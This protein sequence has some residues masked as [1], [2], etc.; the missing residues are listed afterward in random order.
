MHVC[1]RQ[2]L[3]TALLALIRRRLF[4][5]L[6]L[7]KKRRTFISCRTDSTSQPCTDIYQHKLLYIFSIYIYK[8]YTYYCDQMQNITST[9]EDDHIDGWWWW[10]QKIKENAAKKTRENTKTKQT[11]LVLSSKVAFG[12]DFNKFIRWDNINTHSPLRRIDEN[13]K[14]HVAADKW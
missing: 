2:L 13:E 3:F 14:R 12:N 6:R 9:E 7:I 11:N 5:R 10:R 4:H 1:H 8:C